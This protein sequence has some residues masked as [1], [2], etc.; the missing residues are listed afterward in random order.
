MP[1]LPI[2]KSNK[3]NPKTRESSFSSNHFESQSEALP[4]ELSKAPREPRLKLQN[5]CT[6]KMFLFQA[7]GP[8]SSLGVLALSHTSESPG[9]TQC[10]D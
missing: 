4:V 5:T 7:L 9:M 2:L 8:F 6:F 3:S 1:L 10:E